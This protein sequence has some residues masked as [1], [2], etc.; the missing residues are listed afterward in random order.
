MKKIVRL[1]ESDLTRIIKRVVKESKEL[2]ELGGISTDARSW[3]EIIVSEIKKNNPKDFIINGNEYPEV[4]N[5]FPV[6]NFKVK[7]LPIGAFGY[8]QDNSGFVGDNYVVTLV[9]DPNLTHK[10]D[11]SVINH[12]MKHAY[13]D[14]K[15]YENK[16]VGIKDSRFIKDMYTEDFQ[17]IIV[18]FMQGKGR[19]DRLIT[20]LYLYYI[21]SSV[22]Q[23]AYLENIYDEGPNGNMWG[24]GGQIIGGIKLLDNLN[25]TKLNEKTWEELMQADIPF[26]KKFKSKE[27]FISY[28]ERYLKKLG[29]KFRKKINKMKY[30]NFPK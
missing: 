6:D 13:Q 15:R 9:V 21:L 24:Y 20:L 28:S 14:F 16:S 22:E 12:E 8:D 26:V 18:G 27:E 5:V 3:S 23:A 10:I 2:N 7:F 29:E 19:G 1:T 25:L 30:L 4:Y 17:K 11:I